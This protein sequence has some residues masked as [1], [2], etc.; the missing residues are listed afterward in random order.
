[1]AGTSVVK[2]NG[3]L[4]LRESEGVDDCA[5]EVDEDAR[6]LRGYVESAQVLGV[7]EGERVDIR[8]GEAAAARHEEAG[9]EVAVLLLGVL[10]S[11]HDDEGA[12]AD[13][14]DESEQQGAREEDLVAG[15][16][17][18]GGGVAS[19][20]DE[21]ADPAIVQLRKKLPRSLIFDPKS[22]KNS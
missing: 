3:E 15:E 1:M 17:V 5:G 4:A 13:G 9:P 20:H 16:N 12:H 10:G 2:S 11:H 8:E 22:M 19:P 7:S 21:E 14:R 18:V 6:E